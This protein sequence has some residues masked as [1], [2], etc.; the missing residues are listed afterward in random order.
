MSHFSIDS[1]EKWRA[2]VMKEKMIKELEI[3][4]PTMP[5]EG[6]ES[7]NK[8]LSPSGP[9]FYHPWNKKMIFFRFFPTLNYYGSICLLF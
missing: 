6:R 2:Y 5:V 1:N 3:Q 9:Q 7:L 8:L 4:I